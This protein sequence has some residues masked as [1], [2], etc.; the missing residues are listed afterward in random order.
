MHINIT[1]QNNDFQKPYVQ[2]FNHN[3]QLNLL[4]ELAGLTD[5][6]NV[7]V[8]GNVRNSDRDLT[9]NS[10]L[11]LITN[12]SDEFI[13]KQ[14]DHTKWFD[15]LNNSYLIEQKDVMRLYLPLIFNQNNL[16]QFVN[17]FKG[18]T[19]MDVMTCPTAVQYNFTKWAFVITPTYFRSLRPDFTTISCSPN[20]EM[21]RDFRENYHIECDELSFD[22]SHFVI[23]FPVLIKFLP[24][25]T[26][27]T[28]TL[29]TKTKLELIGFD[30]Y[31]KYQKFV[32]IVEFL[33]QRANTL[34]NFVGQRGFKVALI[35]SL[36]DN[37]H[38][39]QSGYWY[40]AHEETLNK[41]EQLLE[42]GEELTRVREKLKTYCSSTSSTE[43]D[44]LVE[45]FKQTYLKHEAQMQ[46]VHPNQEN[47]GNKPKRRIPRSEQRKQNEADEI[48]RQLPEIHQP[49]I[50]R[51]PD[52]GSYDKDKYFARV[53]YGPYFLRVYTMTR[54]QE[55]RAKKLFPYLIYGEYDAK[56]LCRAFY[57]FNLFLFNQQYFQT[58]TPLLEK[59]MEQNFH[60]VMRGKSLVR[61]SEKKKTA[62]GTKT[63]SVLIWLQNYKFFSKIFCGDKNN[64][65][66]KAWDNALQSYKG[67]A[68]Y[69]TR[70][71]TQ[72][73]KHELQGFGDIGNWFNFLIKPGDAVAG[74][75]AKV[76]SNT[77][78][79]FLVNLPSTLK[80]MFM[81]AA[82][83]ALESFTAAIAKV[84]KF[85][86]DVVD[87]IKTFL[88][89][90][91][92][93]RFLQQLPMILFAM[94]VLILL[95]ILIR[96]EL[97]TAAMILAGFALA[98]IALSVGFVVGN[99]F[100]KMFQTDHTE[101][102]LQSFDGIYIALK[103]F[104]SMF[105]LRDISSIMNIGRGIKPLFHDMSEFFCKAWNWVYKAFTGNH[106][107][108][109]YDSIGQLKALIEDCL[110]LFQTPGFE[111]QFMFSRTLTYRVIS[112]ASR[113]TSM[114]SVLIHSDLPASTKI[115]YQRILDELANKVHQ[116]RTS[117]AFFRS[118]P[119]PVCMILRGKGGQGKS[120][121]CDLFPEAIYAHCR[122][123]KLGYFPLDW[124]PNMIYTP[125]T[126]DKF[127]DGIGLDTFVWS[128]DDFLQS[129]N[130]NIRSEDALNFMRLV[131]PNT[132]SMNAAS[133]EKKSNNFATMPFVLL[134][135]NMNLDLPSINTCQIQDPQAFRRRFHLVCEVTR[136]ETVKDVKRERDRA[137]WFELSKPSSDSMKEG[138]QLAFNELPDDV[139]AE[140]MEK[141]TIKYTFSQ[142]C[143][144][145]SR[146]IVERVTDHASQIATEIDWV[147]PA[148]APKTVMDE[149][150]RNRG[151]RQRDLIHMETWLAS[152][153]SKHESSVSELMTNA[154][155]FLQEVAQE[156]P[157]DH[158]MQLHATTFTMKVVQKICKSDKFAD[159]AF[160]AYS[161]PC[162]HG[163]EYYTSIS[164]PPDYKMSSLLSAVIADATAQNK[165]VMQLLSQGVGYE[166]QDFWT[167]IA[168][169]TRKAEDNWDYT[170]KLIVGTYRYLSGSH[171]VEVPPEKDDHD[172]YIDDNIWSWCSE[173][174]SAEYAKAGTTHL[175]GRPDRSSS[176]STR[177]RFYKK[178][179][180]ICLDRLGRS[181]TNFETHKR[182]NVIPPEETTNPFGRV[183][184]K[185]L[186]KKDRNDMYVFA[187][188]FK[189]PG[190][191]AKDSEIA[192][193]VA[194]LFIKI[195]ARDE[196][197]F[198]IKKDHPCRKMWKEQTDCR[199]RNMKRCAKILED[200]NKMLSE[201]DFYYWTAVWSI[202]AMTFCGLAAMA[203]L[204]TYA[205]LTP[206]STFTTQ[207]LS[208]EKLAR[209]A[210]R[211]KL[212]LQMKG[213]S[214]K[215]TEEEVK[216]MTEERIHEVQ[217]GVAEQ[218]TNK[219]NAFTHNIR[220][221]KFIRNGSRYIEIETPVVF[222]GRRAFTAKHIFFSYGTTWDTVE[223]CND[224]E[225]CLRYD[226]KVVTIHMD[227]AVGRDI[228]YLDFPE[229]MP[230]YPTLKGKFFD[231]TKYTKNADRYRVARVHRT[232]VKGTPT[233]QVIESSH[234]QPGTISTAD[235]FDEF[236]VKARWDCTDFWIAI[237]GKGLPGDCGFPY[238]V[239]DT[240]TG[241]VKLL[242]IHVGKSGSDS[243][244]VTMNDKDLPKLVAHTHELQNGKALVIEQ[245][246][247]HIPSYLEP[248]M[249]YDQTYDGRLVAMGTVK[250]AFIPT[251]TCF[252]PSVLQGNA[253][254]P[255]I[256]P[257]TTAPAKLKPFI[258][259]DEGINSD[260]IKPLPKAVAKMTGAP[261]RKF[262]LWI[263][264][265]FQDMQSKIFAGFCPRT[266]K[267]FEMLTIEKACSML[268]QSTSV[269]YDMQCL[270]FKSRHELWT[271]EG[272]TVT[273]IHPILR[274]IVEELINA[275]RAGKSLKNVVAACLKDEL[276][277]LLR[278]N[279]G[280]T[281]LFCVG[282][283]SHLIVTVMVMGDI[284]KYMKDNRG[285]TDA[286]IGI[287]PHG[288]EWQKLNRRLRR[289]MG[290]CKFGGGDFS[291]YDSSIL[292]EFAYG[293]Y[294][295]LKWYTQWDDPFLLWCLR[296]VCIA[297]VAPFMVI[298]RE[299]YWMDWMNSSGGWL[300]G[301][302]NT[303]VNCVI[304]NAYV[305][306]VNMKFGMS[307]DEAEVFIKFF[308]GDDNIW[309]VEDAFV[310]YCD[311]FKLNEFIFEHFGM[312]YT[313]PEKA[314][315]T[316]PFL[317][318]EELSFLCRTLGGDEDCHAK[319][320]RDSI[321]GMLLWIR[322]PKRGVSETT[323]LC[324]NIEQ[325]AMEWY[326][327]GLETFNKETSH[328][329][330]YCKYFGIPYTGLSWD[331]YQ[332]R[333]HDSITYQ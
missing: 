144:I 111:S 104:A 22:Y 281:R 156:W 269:G 207:S 140:L 329:K 33:N 263:R 129:R 99:K 199:Y 53:Q 102:E 222:S 81:K 309:A 38:T 166:V 80:D 196:F 216:T 250:T 96:L 84:K 235:V 95:I 236:G 151:A 58:L 79:D 18:F 21:S 241:D 153:V 278:V 290:H 108:P 298:I 131:S 273:W 266:R 265:A 27:L 215:F 52:L 51:S 198:W 228:V 326:H 64:R 190:N 191:T 219:I 296:C 279:E 188:E 214:H 294:E 132:L 103:M 72:I 179:I 255:P 264:R 195:A 261:I 23:A 74:V 223:I 185:L 315:I 26:K 284:V 205:S 282:S 318:Y 109:E 260:L 36:W 98:G 86:Y 289:W 232:T 184:R 291:N 292:S 124:T 220:K 3:V 197:C 172:G 319:L 256:Y 244:L 45:E 288:W 119:E 187:R 299:L 254:K 183:V 178:W 121:A 114:K 15:L 293:L 252:K 19:K 310:P 148:V 174:V 24:R 274:K 100:M 150:F 225:V 330:E 28:Y 9:G 143:E 270:G 123:R 209:M 243:Y 47:F 101:H 118:R 89:K 97:P 59:T 224:N 105:N 239:T 113:L 146:M 234:L 248:K 208:R 218:I 204:F 170:H 206:S 275:M 303:F 62:F 287:N 240:E 69:E 31:V 193:Y 295:C 142:I 249:K 283:L 16:Q 317:E 306:Y 116:I 211:R 247:L 302:L 286:C 39:T 304:F 202:A 66:S 316:K 155:K 305:M 301:F 63:Q 73:G 82:E 120:K 160:A 126:G 30:F 71:K 221:L 29:Q 85:I 168:R 238:L 70:A 332:A 133:L 7:R 176:F 1:E 49:C 314:G 262:P 328:M 106:Y 2:L 68:Y 242:G 37:I 189:F 4:P 173:S 277:D 203:G 285:S 227:T 77:L 161:D 11:D 40:Q 164:D 147:Q 210:A 57:Q 213:K 276:R 163:S 280:K 91:L 194:K 60:L 267:N 50:E 48:D 181:T 322:K 327:Y 312:T 117:S 323:Q 17:K 5:Q 217:S 128:Q 44:M 130:P 87:T 25:V 20:I 35:R 34:T 115:S 324:I 311:M 154:C 258:I 182:E 212:K 229:N 93:A 94:A 134:S 136:N 41:P 78:K 75:A 162:D 122:S 149:A 167:Y 186:G 169:H 268:D 13:N 54:H 145:V 137:W 112:L 230:E 159:E 201:N 65:I 83:V 138:E 308:Y 300:T 141:G 320:S 6:P 42:R 12:K 226:A 200:I 67:D 10:F 43:E 246:G 90:L 88:L 175:E 297:S 56:L 307:F 55:Q 233:I 92:P 251:E 333:W 325:A 313:T 135:S 171:P 245:N 321:T 8:D 177:K 14:P 76:A 257:I 192:Y 152:L 165:F 157:K 271:K 127:D 180:G 125:A 32:D 107:Y 237:N 272:D 253:E 231:T 46:R 110:E 331:E 61:L 158:V 139:Q 259:T